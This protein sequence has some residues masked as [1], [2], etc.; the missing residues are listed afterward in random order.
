MEETLTR[1]ITDKSMLKQKLEDK[2]KAQEDFYF[3][4]LPGFEEFAPLL[5]QKVTTIFEEE[6]QLVSMVNEWAQH[7][8]DVLWN[9]AQESYSKD[10]LA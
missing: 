9:E 2:E 1:I 6:G 7:D 5:T 4:T 8:L 3:F 10:Y